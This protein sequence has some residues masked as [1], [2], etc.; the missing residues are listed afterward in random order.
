MTGVAR[1]RGRPRG[2]SRSEVSIRQYGHLADSLEVGQRAFVEI[3]VE[4]V[5]TLARRIATALNNSNRFAGKAYSVRRLTA[6]EAR[7]GATP[8]YLLGIERKA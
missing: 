7:F 4:D 2:P 3:S 1:G 5:E 6:L 8:I